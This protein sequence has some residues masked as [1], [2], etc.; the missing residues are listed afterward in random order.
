M[1]KIIQFIS[2]DISYDQRLIRKCTSLSEKGFE[3]HLIGRVLPKSIS[4]KEKYYKQTRWKL[5]FNKGFLFYIELNIRIF[6]YLIKNKFQIVTAND[7]DTAFGCVLASY[8]CNFKLHFDAHELFTEVPELRNTQIKKNIW[9]WLE[10]WIVIRADKRYTVCKSIK[11]ILENN[12]K[13]DFEVIR[14]LPFYNSNKKHSN[15][16]K[17]P[18]ILL[19]QGAVNEGRG[20]KTYIDVLE[21]LQ[22]C[23]LHICGEGD[24]FNE[25]KN[26][27]SQKKWSNKIIWHGYVS[28]E[29][30][31]PITNSAFLILNL[32]ENLGAN[33]Y[34]SLSN[35]FLDAIQS[36]IP[37]VNMNWPEFRDIIQQY[38]VGLL[39]EKVDTEI[40]LNCI[41]A[42]IKD[43]KRY[44]ELHENCIKAALDLNWEHEK[45]KLL[46][47]Y[48]NYTE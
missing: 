25:L 19:Y 24:L 15:F 13:K 34:Y 21:F 48:K 32:L 31:L 12:Y 40:L 18:K 43:E 3:V 28:P 30:L 1:I 44:N 33:Y 20:V 45:E 22:D 17:K 14:N 46:S 4:L 9:K 26:Y 27:S 36:G 38:D 10:K 37:S 5:F 35:K 39:I 42:L 7:V 29:K 8:F 2:N 47:I 41:Q 6:I 23:E 11:Q 16:N